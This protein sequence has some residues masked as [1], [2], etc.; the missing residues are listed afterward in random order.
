MCN[1]SDLCVLFLYHKSDELAEHHLALLEKSNPG[2]AI[3]PIYA[4]PEPDLKPKFLPGTV[5]ARTVSSRWKILSGWKAPDVA[6]YRW[7]LNRKVDAERYIALEYDCLCTVNLREHYASVWNSDIAVVSYFT[8]QQNPRWM[9]F[10]P[11]ELAKLPQDLRPNAAGISPFAGTMFSASTLDQ[12]VEHSCSEEMIGD[13]RIGTYIRKLGLNVAVLPLH[14]RAHIS[15]NEYHWRIEKQ[16]LYHAVKGVDHN[17]RAL[18]RQ[19]GL[20]ESWLVDIGRQLDPARS[21]HVPSWHKA[22]RGAMKIMS[23]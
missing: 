8:L 12:L 14:V 16:G 2:T 9:W 20:I 11:D 10:T 1:K 13:L 4:D 17:S 19:L 23:K 22:C 5:D 7:F 6:V 21:L 3:V 18:P 15:W